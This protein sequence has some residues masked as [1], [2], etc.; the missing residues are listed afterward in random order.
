MSAMVTRVVSAARSLDACCSFTL[1]ASF[2]SPA[3]S[4]SMEVTR[5]VRIL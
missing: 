2:E 3:T 4:D 1:T 5:R